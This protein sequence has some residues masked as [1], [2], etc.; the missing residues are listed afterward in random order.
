VEAAAGRRPSVYCRK[1]DRPTAV[2][3]CP[4]KPND[5]CYSCR[6][7][8]PCWRSRRSFSTNRWEPP[9]A[10]CSL[11]AS[12]RS[13]PLAWIVCFDCVINILIS[14]FFCLHVRQLPKTVSN[15]TNYSTLERK[16]FQHILPVGDDLL[17][18]VFITVKTTG[19]NHLTRLPVIIRTW[20]QLAKKQVCTYYYKFVYIII[21][22]YFTYKYNITKTNMND[23][24]SIDNRFVR[25]GMK[26]TAWLGVYAIMLTRH[27]F[28]ISK[29]NLRY[30]CF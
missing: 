23:L 1:C 2:E 17:E 7:Y 24:K 26:L 9:E 12:N 27:H 25:Y 30:L 29:P 21:I 4:G 3:L 22:I 5:G 8:S 10:T 18:K 13:V 20:F 16:S 28:R 14:L 11:L 15:S 6:Y 19:R